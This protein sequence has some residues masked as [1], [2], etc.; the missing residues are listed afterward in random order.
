MLGIDI[1]KAKFDVALKVDQRGNRAIFANS[2]K[3]FAKLTSW[4]G[5]HQAGQ[6]HACLEATGRYGEA[7][8]L[9]LLES[10]HKVSVVN[11]AR[12]KKYADS[13]L[14]RNKTDRLDAEIIL[15]FCKTQDPPVWKPPT[16]EQRKLQELVRYHFAQQK[17][18]QQERNRKSSGIQEQDVLAE[19]QEHLAYLEQKLEGM[20]TKILSHID[21]H[22]Q[23]K[24]DHDLL[25]TI[26]GIGQLTA[27]RLLAEIPDTRA[28]DNAK[29]LA[30]YAGL[31][32]SHRQSGSS[33]MKR[34]R[35]SK[36]GRSNLR[37]FLYMPALAAIRHNPVIIAQ[38]QRLLAS[39]KE[40][41]VV[42]G[43][44]M[45]KLLHIVYGVLKSGRPFD[46]N[47]ALPANVAL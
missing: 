33:L 44:A 29:Q 11:P 27:A 40:K 9:F 8:A 42:V 32:P 39:G 17:M 47:I 19:L 31:T 43:A 15:D 45:R 41:M 10:G 16:P 5:K 7:L 38:R 1:A 13:Q 2:P 6:V 4:L 22:P 25:V 36:M 30:A 34:P 35:L 26:P 3:G 20:K 23:L 46:K 37:R 28:F 24:Q 14:R 12:I 18:R 21:Q